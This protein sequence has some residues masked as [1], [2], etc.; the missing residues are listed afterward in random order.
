MHTLKPALYHVSDLTA[1]APAARQKYNTMHISVS[2]T[3]KKAQD[4]ICALTASRYEPW[5]SAS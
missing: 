1:M 5:A 3:E 4:I 2:F